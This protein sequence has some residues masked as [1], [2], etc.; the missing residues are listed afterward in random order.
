MKGISKRQGPHQEA[1][2]F[3]TT[4]VPRSGLQ[5]AVEPREAAGEELARTP[6]QRR[7]LRR[8]SGQRRV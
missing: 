1:Q 5:L 7:E 2:R 8:L 3:T 6:V 4:G